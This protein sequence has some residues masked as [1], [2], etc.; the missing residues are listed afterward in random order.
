MVK[1]PVCGMAVGDL[2]PEGELASKGQ[3]APHC[4]AC[5]RPFYDDLQSAEYEGQTY[6]FCSAGCKT[7]FEFGPHKYLASPE[8]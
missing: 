5:W 2:T 7:A 1:C 8:A 6:Y 4:D 3:T